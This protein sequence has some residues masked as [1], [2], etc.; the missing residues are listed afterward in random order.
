M[1]STLLLFM[2][3]AMILG[4]AHAEPFQPGCLNQAVT[5]LSKQLKTPKSQLR[6]FDGAT[7]GDAAAATEVV[8]LSRSGG[9]MW[10]VLMNAEMCIPLQKA[11]RAD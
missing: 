4:S 6:Y 3:S 11:I 7:V 9:G 1:K 8:M 10:L 2:F 5:M